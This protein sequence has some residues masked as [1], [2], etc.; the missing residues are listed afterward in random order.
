[1]ALLHLRGDLEARTART[2]D[3][4]TEE[5]M[6]EPKFKPGDKF[7]HKDWPSTF[8]N[9]GVVLT[10]GWSDGGDIWY[11]MRTKWA[12]P[13]SITE[14][15]MHLVPVSTYTEAQI[16]KAI[17][18]KGYGSLMNDGSERL[19]FDRLRRDYGEQPTGEAQ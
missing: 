19:F 13:C 1:M 6:S 5:R 9:P 18:P 15:H 17:C 12:A 3:M 10:E 8:E 7:T 11:L 2:N 14:T 16:K 4:H